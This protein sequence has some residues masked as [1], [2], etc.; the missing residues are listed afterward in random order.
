MRRFKTSGRT[1]AW[2]HIEEYV[3]V[4]C[5][6]VKDLWFLSEA[7]IA[8]AAHADDEELRVCVV[9]RDSKSCFFIAS[10]KYTNV[11]LR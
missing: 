3:V 1:L 10:G 7:R 11:C 5:F 8:S 6:H 2:H 4:L 9:G